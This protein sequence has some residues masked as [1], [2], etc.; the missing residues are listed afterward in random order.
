MKKVILV[1][2]ASSGIGR[3][4]ANALQAAGHTV[5]G[6]SRSVHALKDIAFIPLKMDITD[7]ESVKSGIET[8]IA[9]EGR[10]DVLI[11]NAGIVL[12]GPLYDTSVEFAKKQFEVNF[13]GVVCV[14][15]A[16]LPGMIERK[17]GLVINISSV[18]G[19]FGLPYVGTYVAAKFALEGYSQSLRMELQNTGVDVT[20]VNPG[21]F[22]TNNTSSR[23]KL[24][25]SL[26]HEKLKREYDAAIEIVEKNEVNGG[27]PAIVGKL[28][29][30]IVGKSKPA[31]RYMVG[32]FDQTKLPLIVKAL[33]PSTM[34]SKMINGYYNIK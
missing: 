14:S 19:L 13:F 1:T 22:K 6:A 2:G 11:N 26:P 8:I 27:N 17:K 28:I 20:V 30:K 16:V 4:T 10:I 23:E 31:H 5:Y 29:T 7:D 18:A 25:F 21:D 24:P 15:T 32:A 33:L 34:F 9:A 12:A 3:E